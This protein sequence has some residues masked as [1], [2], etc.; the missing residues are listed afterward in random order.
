[1]I[2]HDDLI[3]APFEGIVPA[4]EYAAEVAAP[5]YDV[6]SSE[7]A[8]ARAQGHPFSFLHVSKAE[9][10]FDGVSPYDDK[11]YDK[12][13]ENFRLLLQRGIL[14]RQSKPCYFVYQM[15]AGGHTQTGLAVAA[16]VKA[17]LE[18]RI[19]RHELTRI[20][21]ENDR[22]RQIRA[23]G[24][25]TGPALLFNRPIPAVRALLQKIT[26]HAPYFSFSGDYGVRHSLWIIDDEADIALIS[27]AF[28][29]QNEAYIADGHHRSAAAARLAQENGSTG[30]ARFLAIAF[31]A[32]EMKI[33]DY[34]RFVHDL[35]G[36]TAE[37]F[38]QKL[39]GDFELVPSCC[40]K[41]ARKGQFMLYLGSGKWFEMNYKGAYDDA[42]PV[43]RLDVSLLS[44]KVLARLLNITDLRND[45]RIEFV[46]GIRG[47]E[48]VQRLVDAR[49]GSL[50]ILV[51]P[52]AIDELIAVADAH[53][54]MP[55]KS[56]W[57][58]PKPAD[59]PVSNPADDA[60]G[61]IKQT[62]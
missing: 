44:D 6:L 45:E 28:A 10:D 23:V 33:L 38:C 39:A 40:Q 46:G 42:N 52:T 61:E 54:L 13:A 7:E 20:A 5:P 35:N 25:Q 27:K 29:E 41:P 49:P 62:A 58:E 19:K 14:R 36:M 12:A 18:G 17:Y 50:G 4:P 53:L 24:A 1:M 11:V 30:T 26:S 8:K 3:Y 51:Y 2:D 48:E 22:V 57:F 34:N 56:T 60:A 59:G 47:A 37:E 31:F 43:A 21:K 9:I 55:P 32:D 15:Q 16:S